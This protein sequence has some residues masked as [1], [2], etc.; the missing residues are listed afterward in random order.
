MGLM[1]YLYATKDD[2]PLP[3]LIIGGFLALLIGTVFFVQ[4]MKLFYNDG[5]WD[6]SVSSA[7]IKWQSPD[8]EVD[9]SL[10]ANGIQNNH[11]VIAVGLRATIKA[12]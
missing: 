12:G 6:I 10:E 5:V 2:F 11:K 3:M 7:G 1:I 4:R 9:G 8:E